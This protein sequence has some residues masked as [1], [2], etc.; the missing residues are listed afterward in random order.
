MGFGG[1]LGPWRERKRY[2]RVTNCPSPF[3]SALRCNT[4][5][6]AP[7]TCLEES[8]SGDPVVVDHA[9]DRK[10]SQASVLQFLQLHVVHLVLGLSDSQSH[11]V[12]SQVARFAVGVRKHGLHGYVSL[13]GPEFE[14]SHPEDNLE[15]GR[16]S[17]NGGSHVG[18]IDVFVAG[19]GHELLHGESNGGKHRG[20]S[21]LDLGF[22]EPLHVKG[23]G[24]SEGVESDVTDPSL[25]LLGSCQVGKGFRHL[26]VEGG[27]FRC[28]ILGIGFWLEWVALRCM[29]AVHSEKHEQKCGTS[30]RRRRT[31]EHNR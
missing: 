20:T 13:V 17:D 18:I 25:Q 21:V 16:G 10:H 30:R 19:D 5:L 8:I 11:R 3:C 27:G 14:D 24:K 9:T 6:I 28:G 12:E 2:G 4:V 23:I 7:F 29:S 22:P 15:H 31:R 26:R 1:R